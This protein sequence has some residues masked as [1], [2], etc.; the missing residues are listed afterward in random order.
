M[1]FMNEYEIENAALYCRDHPI[2]GPATQTLANLADWTNHNSDGWPYWAKPCRAAQKLQGLIS[3]AMRY[4]YGA[5]AE[6]VTLAE[7]KAALR[8]IKAFR[9]RQGA[10][11]TIYDVG[12]TEV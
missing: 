7:Y 3:E 12:Y 1:M 6:G 9:T 2:L 8:P 4:R 10:D 5:D 11:F